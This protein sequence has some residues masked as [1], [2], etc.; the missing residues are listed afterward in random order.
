M[1]LT[2]RLLF[3]LTLV[4]LSVSGI[5]FAETKSISVVLDDDYPPYSFRD[6][7][8]KLQGITEDR[9]A[10][11]S[12]KTGIAVNLLGMDWNLALASM[13]AGKAD[14]ID[15]I[16]SSPER[17]KVY[18]FSQPY[19]TID[20]PVFFHRSISGI[21]DA[22]SL[23]GFSV[24]AKD[25]DFCVGWLNEHGID[26][27]KLFSSF[28]AMVTAAA[29]NDV[30]VFCMDKPQAG[31]LLAKHNI[32]SEFRYSPPL[33]SGQLHWATSKDNKTLHQSIAHGFSLISEAELRTIDDKWL[34]T[35]VTASK[36]NWAVPFSYT[37]LASS[38]VALIL[39]LWNWSLRNRVAIRTR[40][41]TTAMDALNS[42]RQHYRALVDTVPVGVFETDEKGKT[43]YVNDRTLDTTG[44]KREQALQNGWQEYLHPDDV[45]AVNAAWRTAIQQQQAFRMEFRFLR[46][47]G[48]KAWVLSQAFP[49]KDETGKVTHY[50]GCFTDISERKL[51]EDQIRF[52]AYHDPLTELP[53]RLLMRDRFD[54]A[55]SHANRTEA[56][57]ALL[58]LDLDHFK[59]IN[60]TLGHPAGDDLLC[61]VATRLE[62][63]L[64][65][66][67]TICRQGGDEFL[68]LLNNLRSPEEAG[69]VATKILEQL[70]APIP[71]E[72]HE[73]ST[74]ISIGIALYPD[75]GNNFDTLLKQAD[76]AMYHAKE[77]GRNTYHYFTEQMNHDSVEHLQLRT[78]L[79]RAV[80]RDELRLHY[81]PQIDMVSGEI[82]GVE[83]LIRWLHPEKGLIPPGLFIPIAENSGLIVS[84]GEW[85]LQEACR[86]AVAWQQA[87]HEL[88]VA[89]NLSAIQLKRSDLKS[90]VIAALAGSGLAPEHLELE[91]TESILIQD[92]ENVLMIV[93]E[94][95]ALGIKL[96][97]D[98]FGTGY[99]SLAY[100]RR[101]D[102]D[103][104]KIDQSFVRDLNDD[105]DDAAIV[106][107]IIQMARSLNLRT[108]AE[109][110]E[111]QPLV[112]S[113]RE[114][115]CDELQ[116]YHLGRPMPPDDFIRYLEGWNKSLFQ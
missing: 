87:G 43:V 86:Q 60:D 112:E 101:L 51:A 82:I 70:S 46:P 17:E 30:R 89:V 45:N 103:K 42:S 85:V 73:L 92:T 83:A 18:D 56:K 98:D 94:L 13:S 71:V 34:G 106:R 15:T 53:N 116:G 14:A 1:R 50:I 26:N 29:G 52:L 76:T 40:E 27:I 84:I 11:W 12:K 104:L 35:P 91:L 55:Q 19:A 110:V 5:A 80:E 41:V 28:A 75:D 67:D 79:A 68:I 107:A 33:Y 3:L 24:G 25:K 61:A 62:L 113:L 10:L 64:R 63:C 21:T 37:L 22:N 8:G 77:S 95:K 49:Q 69:K 88:T 31:Y 72:G 90:T 65:D 97:I 54:L 100:L 93:T 44:A 96:S 58:L 47:D 6:A 4:L 9:W 57:L 114:L 74:S 99:S 81:Q 36:R 20:V 102:V 59:T 109:G 108:I 2:A 78:H 7:Q 39:F 23:R 66:T 48:T 111:N 32:E 105:A 115:Q 38:I 16:F